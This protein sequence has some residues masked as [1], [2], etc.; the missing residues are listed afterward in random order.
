MTFGRSFPSHLSQFRHLQTCNA[1]QTDH[2]KIASQPQK[3]TTEKSANV[4]SDEAQSAAYLTV[5]QTPTK[6]TPS[7]RTRVASNARTAAPNKPK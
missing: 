3:L 5:S 2:V 4:F 1:R 7:P 6:T